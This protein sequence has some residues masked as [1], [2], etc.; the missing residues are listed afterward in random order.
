MALTVSVKV[1]G[2]ADEALAALKKVFSPRERANIV[3]RAAQNEVRNYL[4]AINLQRPNKLGG[5]RTNYFSGAAESTEFN[6]DDKGT[7]VVNIHQVGMRMKYTGGKIVPRR[8]KNLTIPARSEAY[9]KTAKEFDNLQVVFGRG[10][11]AIGLAERES[12]DISV[13]KKKVKNKGSRGG[14]M[15]FWLVKEVNVTADKT[16]MP[17]PDDILKAS[18]KALKA[19]AR[20]AVKKAEDTDGR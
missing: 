11:K 6:A 7:A 9:G 10:R 1:S 16:V 3:G 17:Q 5:T 20:I 2:N 8:A 15:M 4:F 13:G 14:G 12:T 19:A 18:G